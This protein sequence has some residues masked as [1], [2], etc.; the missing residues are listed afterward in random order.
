MKL[1]VRC[2]AKINLFLAVGKCDARGYHP[3]RTILQAVS[4]FDELEISDETETSQILCENFDLPPRN[5]IQKALSLLSEHALI[6]PLNITLHKHIP[7][8]AGLGGGSSDAAGVLR[9]INRFIKTPISL[10]SQVEIARAIGVD[11]SF[12]LIGGRAFGEGYGE[13][14]TPLE[15]QPMWF[16]LAKP[17]N[18]HGPTAEMYAKLDAIN[19]PFIEPNPAVL[20]LHNDFLQVA[21]RECAT[22]I[23]QLKASGASDAML[24]GSGSAVFGIFESEQRAKNAQQL[25]AKNPAIWSATAKAITS[26]E[27]LR[28]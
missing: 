26:E 1:L 5:T 7:S 3:V 28:I 20:Q 11:T 15:F 14:L 6:P 18:V 8:E 10:E 27:S 12:F 17:L 19:Y 22:L 2:P 23:E 24:T 9:A 13:K 16:L 4:L 25:I 21:P